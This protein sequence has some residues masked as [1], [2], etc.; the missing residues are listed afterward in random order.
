M[1]DVLSHVAA[2]RV[3]REVADVACGL[4]ID[5]FRSFIS[6]LATEVAA[7]TQSGEK[8]IIW[9]QVLDG[10]AKDHRG[11]AMYGLQRIG[12]LDGT[13]YKKD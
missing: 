3:M 9:K 8:T 7:L 12:L 5:E 2:R 13:K 4:E 10:M 11:P 1:N 6:Q